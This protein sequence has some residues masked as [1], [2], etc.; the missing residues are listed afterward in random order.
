MSSAYYFEEGPNEA[1]L[2]G[3]HDLLKAPAGVRRP[4][5]KKA[6]GVEFFF[7]KPF[8]RK[9]PFMQKKVEWRGQSGVFAVFVLLR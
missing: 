1:A 4:V 7:W 5:N 2:V 8:G 3:Y 6:L 9:S